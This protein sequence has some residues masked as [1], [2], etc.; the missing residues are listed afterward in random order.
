MR[1]T[2]R[3]KSGRS[4]ELAARYGVTLIVDQLYARL[5]FSGTAYRHLRAADIDPDQV[6]TIIGPSKTES[7][8][9][10]RQGVAFGAPA[11]IARME[12]LQA[13]V[14]LRAAGYAQ[15]V[16]ETWFAEPDGWMAERIALHEAIRDDLH[17]RLT[18]VEGVRA[19][20]PQ[21]G[22]YLFPRL[23]K[24][25]VSGGDFVRI[26]RRQA[27]VTVTPGTEFGPQ[28]GDSIRLNFSQDHRAAA[29]AVDRI[30]QMIGRYRA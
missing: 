22:S 11:I 13:I 28:F 12:K 5:R 26:L 29:A 10:Y 7:L 17:A 14:S 16:L 21:A 8:S 15:S 18:V 3:T 27:A 9:G 24:L 30:V 19:R 23:P 20:L 25:T 2:G 1:S 6:I 4:H